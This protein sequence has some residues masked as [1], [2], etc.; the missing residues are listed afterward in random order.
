MSAH[1]LLRNR[2]RQHNSDKEADRVID[3]Y[4]DE[5]RGETRRDVAAYVR[6]AK[7]AKP[8]GEAEEHVNACLDDLARDIE[9]GTA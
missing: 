3:L 5:V 6:N 8:L 1:S 4:R 2:L 9:R 7:V